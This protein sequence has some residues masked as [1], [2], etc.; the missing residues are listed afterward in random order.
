MS[1]LSSAA[2]SMLGGLAIIVYSSIKIYVPCGHASIACTLLLEGVCWLI[3]QLS[4]LVNNLDLFVPF[5]LLV[6]RKL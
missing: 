4:S 6:N 3:A 1:T 2:D 5:N